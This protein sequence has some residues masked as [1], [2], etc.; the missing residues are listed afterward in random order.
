MT[1]GT[2]NMGLII[3]G[4]W[5]KTYN[6]KTDELGFSF[7]VETELEAYQAAYLYREANGG[8]GITQ[9][10]PLQEGFKVYV[11]FDKKQVRAMGFNV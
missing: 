7:V 11:Y 1:N 6:D 4:K 5:I 2:Y 10:K 3:N 8:K 9:V